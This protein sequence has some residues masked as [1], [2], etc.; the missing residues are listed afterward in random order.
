MGCEM[1]WN[2]LFPIPLQS[3]YIYGVDVM[4]GH[5]E[6]QGEWSG[7]NDLND[8]YAKSIYKK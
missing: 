1:V 2:A 3:Y 5:K 4:K 6:L 7:D 8:G